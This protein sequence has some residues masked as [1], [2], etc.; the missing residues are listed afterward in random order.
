[1][2]KTTDSQP[3][4]PNPQSPFSPPWR[5]DFPVNWEEDHHVTRRQFTSLLALL[6][7]A[8]FLGTGLI[9]LQSW[10]RRRASAGPPAVRIA[11]R[12][13]HEGRFAV[14]DGRVLAGPPQRPLPRVSLA[15]Q[16]EEIWATGM[17][18]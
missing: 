9:G 15:S 11:S 8:F 14:E 17:K 2:E 3:L 6:S 18:V 4:T 1:M 16:G 7:S 13:D 12:A 10:W 5:T